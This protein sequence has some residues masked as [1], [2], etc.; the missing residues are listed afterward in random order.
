MFPS[1]GFFSALCSPALTDHHFHLLSGFTQVRCGNP[2]NPLRVP[3]SHP[4]RMAVHTAIYELLGSVN[5]K[6]MTP[7]FQIAYRTANCQ[8]GHESDRI[9]VNTHAVLIL[10]RTKKKS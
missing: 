7:P 2:A 5:T 4:T 9:G 6:L 10:V 3:T 8:F 1:P